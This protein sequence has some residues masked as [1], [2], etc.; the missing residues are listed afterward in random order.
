MSRPVSSQPFTARRRNLMINT[1]SQKF[2]ITRNP[3][4]PIEMNVAPPDELII[5]HQKALQ[6]REARPQSFHGNKGYK[7]EMKNS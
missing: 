4:S 3:G 2:M 5:K 6:N 7:S 1:T